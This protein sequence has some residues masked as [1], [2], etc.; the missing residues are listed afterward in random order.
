MLMRRL[1]GAA[2]LL[3][4]GLAVSARAADDGT[5]P[6]NGGHWWDKLNPFASKKDEVPTIPPT[7]PLTG[8]TGTT[9]AARTGAPAAAVKPAAANGESEEDAFHRRT[10]VCDQLMQ[11]A[12]NTSNAALERKAELLQQRIDELY[13]LR[14]AARVPK[15]ESEGRPATLQEEHE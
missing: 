3:V 11:I 15:L 14:T 12:I 9:A 8:N 6:S 1:G 7:V 13:R 4:L 5:A 2:A 10:A